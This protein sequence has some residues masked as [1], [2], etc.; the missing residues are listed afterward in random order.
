MKK[1]LAALFILTALSSTAIAAQP[2]N[3]Q[4]QCIKQILE[5]DV[6]YNTRSFFNAIQDGNIKLVD[7]FLKSGMSPNS[8]YL[9]VPALYMAIYSHQNEVVDLL[10]KNG[11]RPNGEFTTGETPLIVAI[12]KK[13]P[14]I[15]STLIK[16]GAD[17]NMPAG[18]LYPLNYAIKKNNKPIVTKLI[19][20][21]AK[22]N[23]DAV[24]R[25]LKCKD[26]NIKSLV[27]KEYKYQK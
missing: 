3:P 5:Q 17:V 22:T 13:D 12:K 7:L 27:L 1:L 25:A 21:G 24:L 11:V 18:K 9:K 26:D 10:L 4:E 6:N 20:A 2:L 23:E 14:A 19:N 16:Y 8:T 15:V